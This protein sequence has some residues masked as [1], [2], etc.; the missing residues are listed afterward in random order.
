MSWYVGQK[1]V[2][3]NGAFPIQIHEWADQCPQ[4]GE[5][6]T[7]RRVA[8]AAHG[9]TGEL[10]VSLLLE[11]I[12]NPRYNEGREIMFSG[13]RF[14]PLEASDKAEEAITEPRPVEA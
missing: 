1:A 10:A 7:I 2:C 12:I 8:M 4:E 9:I 13:D 5:V 6:Y 14:R 11:E 3:V